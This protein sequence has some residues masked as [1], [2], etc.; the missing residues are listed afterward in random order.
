M[1][2]IVHYILALTLIISPTMPL[3][4][5][6]QT[7]LNKR[8]TFSQKL[9]QWQQSLQKRFALPNQ[10]FLKQYG[11]PI[12][13]GG[14]AIASLLIFLLAKPKPKKEDDY[15]VDKAND[16]L[17][18]LLTEDPNFGEVPNSP[19]P[20]PPA[21]TPITANVLNADALNEAKSRLRTKDQQ[22]P[23]SSKIE[24][25]EDRIRNGITGRRPAINGHLS[26]SGTL[27]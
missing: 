5:S 11:A 13:L 6:N 18:E 22:K 12:A 26:T 2:S 10:Q 27:S 14:L 4:S 21:D 24:T 1:K 7:A 8:T 15:H 16:A 9:S 3:L 23:L 25:N 17:L 20:T 19:E